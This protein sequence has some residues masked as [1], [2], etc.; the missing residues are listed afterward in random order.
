MTL[1]QVIRAIERIASEQPAIRMIVRNDVFR[2]NTCPDAKYGTFAWLQR[3][4]SG[5][6]DGNT[7]RYSFTF[8][9]VDR[10]TADHGNEVEIQSTGISTLDNII[11]TLDRMGIWCDSGYTFQTFNQ[12]FLDECAGVFC[13][14]AFDVPS[15]DLCPEEYDDYS[16]DFS[17]D[18]TIY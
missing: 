12:R 1:R 8:F 5:S 11:K 15:G 17:E 4:H 3:E 18:F 6:V 13:N 16:E 2:L 10:L 9:Y 14:V 7:I